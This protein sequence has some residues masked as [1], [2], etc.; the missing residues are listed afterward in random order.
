MR[1]T[2]LFLTVYFWSI[3]VISLLLTS[4]VCVLCYPFVSQKTFARIYGTIPG[5][6]M[7]NAMTIP[8]FWTLTIED[9]R[10]DKSWKQCVIVANHE[11][12]IDSLILSH[13]PVTK[14]FMIGKVF[15]DIPIFGWL[16]KSSGYVTADKN[17]PELNKTSVSRAVATMQDG[18]CFCIFPEAM[19]NPNP[20]TLLPFKTGA[21]R[22]AK[23][24][25]VPILPI[26]LKNTGYAMPIGG[27]VNFANISMVI[28]EPFFVEDEPLQV[29]INKSRE[30]ISSKF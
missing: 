24:T 11:S 7:L 30:V 20:K 2:Q 4:V 6:L 19:R 21:Y 14:K 27:L 29:Y 8:G 18:S 13:I 1:I 17:D 10:R 25:K 12:M 15:T 23:E 3:T 28:H 9:W 16:A 5:S 26:T 22:I